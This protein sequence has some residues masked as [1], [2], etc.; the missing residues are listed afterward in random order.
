M[1][2]LSKR[3]IGLALS[4]GSARGLAHSGVV[5]ALQREGVPIDLIA[6]TSVE[7]VI[8][9]HFAQGKDVSFLKELATSV[10]WKK[11]A[12]LV[13]LTLPRTGFIRGNRL[14]KWLESIVNSDVKFSDLKIPFAC[15]ATDIHSFEEVVIGGGSVLDGIRASF[16][17]PVIFSVVK[18][19]GRYL[20]D[21]GLVNPVPVSVLKAMGADFII[22]VDVIPDRNEITQQM[23]IE[24][25]EELKEPNI[26]H[27]MMQSV[28]IASCALVSPCLEDSDI[29]I[30]PRV[31]RFNPGNFLQAQECIQEG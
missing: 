24:G 7:A 5:E 1:A 4:S 10:D 13:D 30:H 31:A 2:K 6:D 8:G 18:S 29:V 21:G 14:K 23:E 25:T 15:V 12:L 3:K 9:A 28:Y 22:E 26:F 20:V 19:K 11:M 17:V 27:A 16:S